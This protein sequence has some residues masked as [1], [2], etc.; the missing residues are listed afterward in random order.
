[1][2]N[3]A[4]SAIAWLKSRLA[5]SGC[6]YNDDS[7]QSIDAAHEALRAAYANGRMLIKPPPRYQREGNVI[8]FPG[9]Q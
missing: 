5:E 1:M 7:M 9:C 6:T 8:R 3:H 2:R 4:E